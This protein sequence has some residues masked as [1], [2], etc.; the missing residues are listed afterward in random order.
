[1]KESIIQRSILEYLFRIGLVIR[2]NNAPVFDPKLKRFRQANSKF[3]PYGVSDI[4]FFSNGGF[5]AFEV[6]TEKEYKYLM[7]NYEEIR[8]GFFSHKSKNSTEKKKARLQ[9]QILFLESFRKQGGI[10]D[11]VFNLKMVAKIIKGDE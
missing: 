2:Y 9:S 3:Q 8:N 6:K 11:F 4:F 5:F 10:G 7:K 1:M